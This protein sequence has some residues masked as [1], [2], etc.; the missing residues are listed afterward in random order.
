M[1]SWT[2][3]WLEEQWTGMWDFIPILL[4][5]C[6]ILFLCTWLSYLISLILNFSLYDSKCK[7]RPIYGDF[8][9][10]LGDLH[11]LVWLPYPWLAWSPGSSVFPDHTNPKTAG[12]WIQ[13]CTGFKN[14]LDCDGIWIINPNLL[15]KKELSL[16]K[17]WSVH[18]LV[19]FQLYNKPKKVKKTSFPVSLSSL[20]QL[21]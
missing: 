15:F 21:L 8:F 20:L 17:K 1:I 19:F 4:E 2:I 18:P 6:Y 16:V 9:I 12:W 7:I 5:T 14:I 13:M 10:I 11:Y 3:S